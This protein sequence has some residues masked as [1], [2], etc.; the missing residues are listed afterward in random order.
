MGLGAGA[1][2]GDLSGGSL[3]V[4][5][6]WLEDR[7][8]SSFL[9]MMW[10]HQGRPCGFSLSPTPYRPV[11][12]QCYVIDSLCDLGVNQLSTFKAGQL[13]WGWPPNPPGSQKWSALGFLKEPVW[14]G[15]PDPVERFCAG[16]GKG[17]AVGFTCTVKLFFAPLYWNGTHEFCLA[18][19]PKVYLFQYTW[20]I[21][22]HPFIY[23]IQSQLS[24]R[25]KK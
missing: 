7:V 13:V 1:C 5:N 6:A 12:S 2:L 18:I 9:T 11:P 8:K 19:M 23:S 4:L 3:R 10:P 20:Q 22:R 17:G 16:E 14:A 24:P 15:G 21:Q 25:L